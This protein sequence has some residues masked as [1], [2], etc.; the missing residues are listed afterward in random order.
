MYSLATGEFQESHGLPKPDING[1]V[2]K[3]IVQ[4]EPESFMILNIRFNQGYIYHTTDGQQW[5]KLGGG[6]P[7]ELFYAMDTD[8][9]QHPKPLFVSTDTLVYRS[10]D[11]GQTWSNQSSGLPRRPHGAD[12][13]FVLTPK[14]ERY[15]YL[16]TYGR[17]VWRT[18]V[19]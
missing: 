7:T 14:N 8:W 6:L 4:D 3:I 15:L 1:A 13:R 9:T 16:S 17:S 10:D 5:Q 11:N 18:L 12:I 2:T 19:K